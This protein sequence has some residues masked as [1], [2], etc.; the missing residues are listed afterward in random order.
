MEHLIG[1][2]QTA[3]PDVVEYKGGAKS[4]LQYF[5]QTRFMFMKDV[6]L[7]LNPMPDGTCR[8]IKSQYFKNGFANFFR[9][10]GME[11]QE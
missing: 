3:R 7:P 9:G 10:G 2:T 11:Q 5:A 4:A 6:I 1:L 8:T